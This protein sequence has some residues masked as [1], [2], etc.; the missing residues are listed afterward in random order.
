MSFPASNNIVP[1]EN[2][3]NTNHQ[4]LSST[5]NTT[6][7]T[8]ASSTTN[9]KTT[10]MNHSTNT[11]KPSNYATKWNVTVTP[12]APNQTLATKPILQD[13]LTVLQRIHN[14]TWI[15]PFATTAASTMKHLTNPNDIPSTEQEANQYIENAR[16]TNTGKLQF[17]LNILTNIDMI[18]IITTATFRKWAKQQQIMLQ[19]S[20]LTTTAP[21]YVG[22]FTTP[23]PE[24]KKVKLMAARIQQCYTDIN[25]PYQIIITPVSA[26]GRQNIT[27]FYMLV[28]DKGNEH[29][30]ARMIT[31]SQE[32]NGN[33]FIPWNQY[34]ALNRAHKVQLIRQQR[35]YYNACRSAII[36][37]FNGNDLPM[38]LTNNNTTPTPSSAPP[39]SAPTSTEQKLS[40]NPFAALAPDNNDIDDQ[41]EPNKPM[42]DDNDI[43]I[44]FTEEH[45]E[46]MTNFLRNHYVDSYDEPMFTIVYPPITNHIE[47]IYQTKRETEV[48]NLL[49]LLRT[50]LLHHM[51]AE[52][53]WATFTDPTATIKEYDDN[54]LWEPFTLGRDLPPPDTTED[55]PKTNYT[56]KA[57]RRNTTSTICYDST[58]SSSTT[59]T[60]TTPTTNTTTQK[61]CNENNTNETSNKTY[62]TSLSVTAA[63][64]QQQLPTES[65]NTNGTNP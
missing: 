59:T 42:E 55:T 3:K 48:N 64:T 16:K 46:T 57:K 19:K 35:L 12:T 44:T 2:N 60:T 29:E 39:Q 51:S 31:N 7:N 25:L 63:T 52:C 32:L 23:L 40:N 54:P 28:C 43:T 24:L 38:N 37:G 45:N 1:I 8:T 36:S 5:N 14:T 22:F 9:N 56:R 18:E 26:E 49:P 6:S 34:Q 41:H 50:D 65:N 30:L 10:N 58:E 15:A 17:R 62:A 13:L 61:H 27:N 33:N 21:S 53:V 20:E 4:Q 11:T 47:L